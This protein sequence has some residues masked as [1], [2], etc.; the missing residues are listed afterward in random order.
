MNPIIPIFPL[1][2]VQFPGALTPLHIFENRYRK[3]IRDVMEA[4]KTFGIIYRQEEETPDSE[5]LGPGSVGC[6]VEVAVVQG[7]PD[8]R[9]NILCVGMSRFR[10][11]DYIEGEPYLQAEV[12]YFDDDPNL[13]DLDEDCEV[14]KSLFERLIQATRSLGGILDRAADE[15]PELPDDPQALSMILGAYL[16]IEPAEKQ[17]FLEM[18]D[19]TRRLGRIRKLLESLTRESEHRAAIHHIARKNGHG[20]KPPNL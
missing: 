5:R 14:A 9:S 4:D 3:M 2:L 10:L 16:D 18:T 6:A 8:G 17:E 13:D 12:E 15:I 11:L 1:S 19:T 7:L 20:G